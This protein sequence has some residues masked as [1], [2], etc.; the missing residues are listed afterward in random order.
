VNRRQRA[1][2]Y[3]GVILAM[4]NCLFPP[5]VYE[6]GWT[7]AMRS[8]GYHFVWGSPKKASAEVLRSLFSIEPDHPAY[9]EPQRYIRLGIDW[10]RVIL[11]L[12]ILWFLGGGIWLKLEDQLPT[13]PAFRGGLSMATGVLF[14]AALVLYLWP[15]W[16]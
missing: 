8:A 7:S 3:A 6:N 10:P 9:D 12:L 4:L 5:W 13:D 16:Q 15:R 1:V 2:F 11:N 14:V